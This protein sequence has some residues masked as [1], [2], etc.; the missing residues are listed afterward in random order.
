MK[1]QKLSALIDELPANAQVKAA[2][3]KLIV[4]A[5]TGEPL[6]YIDFRLQEFIEDDDEE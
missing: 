1:A 2:N 5:K 3:G 6:G 4:S